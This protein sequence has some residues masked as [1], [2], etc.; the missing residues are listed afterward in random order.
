MNGYE[1][2][3]FSDAS[4]RAILRR[5][6]QFFGF[7]PISIQILPYH[8]RVGLPKS[9]FLVGLPVKILKELSPTSILATWL[10]HLNIINLVILNILGELYEV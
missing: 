5:I 9:V 2:R 4:K 6:I 3:I 7:R 8:I 10:T 1:T